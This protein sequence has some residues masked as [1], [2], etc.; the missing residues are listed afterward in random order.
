MF[1]SLDFT[2][3]EPWL[4]ILIFAT[5]IILELITVDLF[6]IWFTVGALAAFILEALGVHLGVQVAVFLILSC[7]LMFTVGK[8]ARDKL[9]S[10]N[11]TNVDALIG[12]DII[13][14][15][16]TSRLNPGEG[17]INGIVWSTITI[18]N[19]EIKAGSVA[20]IVEISGN[21]LYVKNKNLGGE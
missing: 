15:K 3:F 21:K 16:D 7:A 19:D 13:I 5:T 20:E 2:T 4:W 6:C 9:K 1:L 11:A 17:K 14:L 10:N 12:Q 8:W 18:D